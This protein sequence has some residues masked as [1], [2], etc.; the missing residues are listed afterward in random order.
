MVITCESHNPG[1]F[2]SGKVQWSQTRSQPDRLD[3]CH[4]LIMYLFCCRLS[5]ECGKDDS[6]SNSFTFKHKDWKGRTKWFILSVVFVYVFVNG[7]FE[8]LMW[9]KYFTH[10]SSK[11]NKNINNRRLNPQF[12]NCPSK[13]EKNSGYNLKKKKKKMQDDWYSCCTS[14]FTSKVSNRLQKYIFGGFKFVQGVAK[15]FF[16]SSGGGFPHQI[17]ENVSEL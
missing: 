5:S 6:G 11:S 12:D 16:Q 9:G 2:R 1:I 14:C 15:L 10:T 3:R 4:W 8:N 7:L 17:Q 13:S